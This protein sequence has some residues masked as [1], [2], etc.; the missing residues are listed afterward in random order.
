MGAGDLKVRLIATDGTIHL[1]NGSGLRFLGSAGGSQ[2]TVFGSL[3]DINAAF[4][5]LVF[6]PLPDFFGVAGLRVTVS[7]LGSSGIGTAQTDDDVLEITVAP[8]ND[9]PAFDLI[10][11]IE[12][13]EDSGSVNLPI[14]G[15]GAGAANEAEQIVSVTVISSNL[16]L[17]ATPLIS[18][19]GATRVLNLAP[20]SNASGNTTIT[21]TAVDDGGTTAGGKDTFTRQFTVTVLPVNDPP[22]PADDRYEVDEDNVLNVIAPGVLGN[23]TTDNMLSATLL[24]GPSRG[25]LSLN[26]DGSF[27]YTPDLDTFGED[28]FVYQAVDSSGGSV[29]ALA[30]IVVRPVNDRPMAQDDDV[31]T[32]QDVSIVIDVLANDHD[33]DG[34]LM[35]DTVRVVDE[36]A[37]GTGA[38]ANGQITFVPNVGFVGSDSLT[39][40]VC[41]DAEPSACGMATIHIEVRLPNS[42]PVA[43]DDSVT[44]SEELP[45]SIDVLAN[46]VDQDGDLLTVTHFTQGSHG[47]VTLGVD[48]LTYLPEPD[49]FGNDTFIY[50]ISDGHAETSTAKVRIEVQGVNDI[51]QTLPETLFIRPNLPFALATPGVLANDSDADGDILTAALVGRPAHGRVELREDGSF[52][53]AANV[54]GPVSDS[55]TYVAQD[56]SS[57]SQVTTVEIIVV[58]ETVAIVDNEPCSTILE[59]IGDESNPSVLPYGQFGVSCVARPGI[60][61]GG[62]YSINEGDLLALD[63]SALSDPEDD[64]LMFSWDVNGD[65]VFGD[66]MGVQPILS[67]PQLQTLGID[68]DGIF[69]VAVRVADVSQN[70]NQATATL[71]VENVAPIVTAAMDQTA[72]K[73]SPSS[74]SLGSFSDFGDD[75]PWQVDVDWGDGS[76]LDT[77]SAANPGSLGALSHTYIAADV[78]DV[79]VMVREDDGAGESGIATFEV[80]VVGPEAH[81]SISG[82]VYA[83]VNNNGIKDPMELGLPN[84]PIVL[85]GSED[86]TLL[87]G[88]DGRYSFS[89]LPPGVYNVRETQPVAFVD[90]IDTPGA[91]LSGGVEDDYFHDVVLSGDATDAADYNFGELG[92]RAD[93]VS[94]SFFLA[95]SPPQSLV[96]QQYLTITD[97]ER[98]L[99]FSAPFDA[100]M[101]TEVGAEGAEMQIELYTSDMLP[102]KLSH[103]VSVQAVTIAEGQQYVLYIGGNQSEMS[104]TIRSAIRDHR[105]LITIQTTRWT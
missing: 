18:G 99:A 8:V 38:A 27:S 65:G 35:P 76:I 94:K 104:A 100:F 24:I 79:T 30:R 13:F 49:F 69:A 6:N 16:D 48:G 11:D 57:S 73:D 26:S 78:Y 98:W 96:I 68:D 43:I 50:D 93:L 41:D 7:D 51:P 20:A 56:G 62:P 80:T 72:D 3:A 81:N 89:E 71:I 55:F 63:A 103:G 4:E 14:T 19:F 5:G 97:H 77:F 1:T 60:S 88:S 33:V 15:F 31:A 12:M 34:E 85:T 95:S 66:A 46:D 10:A 102:V 9:P 2:V 44:T 84:V 17:I 91:P 40:Q 54:R 105:L 53:Y 58:A 23:D 28:T 22:S 47:A 52:V 64:P 59:I 29:E 90:G 67:W 83:D 37:R 25:S 21:I 74:F 82:Y 45:I 70:M 32:V 61:A 92:L 86:R 75:L 36:P 101:T 39:Y 87:S 42:T